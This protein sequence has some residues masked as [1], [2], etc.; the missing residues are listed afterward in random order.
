[1]TRTRTLRLA[2]KLIASPRQVPLHW[3][4]FIA[5]AKAAL[6]PVAYMIADAAEPFC[7]KFFG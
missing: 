7:G 1:M 2:R 3:V 6:L 4:W 5:V